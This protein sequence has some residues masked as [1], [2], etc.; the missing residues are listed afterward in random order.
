MKSGPRE[1]GIQQLVANSGAIFAFLLPTIIGILRPGLSNFDA[2]Y[3]GFPIIA[4]VMI[5]IVTILFLTIKETPTGDGFLRISDTPIEIDSITLEHQVSNMATEMEK[6][7]WVY[8]RK[9]LFGKDRSLFFL[10]IY[11]TFSY[12]AFASIEAFFT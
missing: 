9:A 12:T 4:V 3:L 5:I 11:V 10:M 2:R 1:A 6:R 8:F 7:G